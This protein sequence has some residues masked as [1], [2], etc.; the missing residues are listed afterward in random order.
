[1]PPTF[2]PYQSVGQG[3][4]R[5]NLSEGAE[6]SE[7]QRTMTVLSKSLD[8]MSTFFFNK[9]E[10]E[11]TIEGEKFGIENMSLQKLKETKISLMYQSLATLFLEKRQGHQL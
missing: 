3:L 7:A 2:R 10:E 8:R 11:A 6:A 4:N 5:L 9:A 1:M